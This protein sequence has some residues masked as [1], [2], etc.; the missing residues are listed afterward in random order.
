MEVQ[1]SCIVAAALRSS[2]REA[3]RESLGENPDRGPADLRERTARFLPPMAVAS[4]GGR[5]REGYDRVDHRF[6]DLAARSGARP[7]RMDDL[8]RLH[9]PEHGIAVARA[10]D[11]ETGVRPRAIWAGSGSGP[12]FAA[13]GGR[14]RARSFLGRPD[15]RRIALC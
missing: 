10:A 11:P 7:A 4:S 9:Q 6:R 15:G 8:W 1:E 12:R 5:R 3:M 14:S 13:R 2:H